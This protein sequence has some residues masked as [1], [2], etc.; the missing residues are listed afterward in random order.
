[1]PL[2][3]VQ[4]FLS[5]LHMV[6]W[7]SRQPELPWPSIEF[8]AIDPSSRI[9]CLVTCNLNF[10][11]FPCLISSFDDHSLLSDLCSSSD[12]LFSKWCYINFC[13]YNY[14]SWWRICSEKFSYNLF[15]FFNQ[16]DF[17]ELIV[18]FPLLLSTIFHWSRNF[19]ELSLANDNWP[20]TGIYQHSQLMSFLGISHQNQF[21]VLKGF[22]LLLKSDAGTEVHMGSWAR[23]SIQSINRGQFPA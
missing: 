2:S 18:V 8:F 11:V 13:D 15:H 22:I 4:D 16:Q 14:N 17:Y 6:I 21:W 3:L 5:L 20:V 12:L 19:Y 9:S 10:L 7:L 1:M 23:R